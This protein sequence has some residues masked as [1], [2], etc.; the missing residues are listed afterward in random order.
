MGSLLIKNGTVVT[1]G[2]LGIVDPGAVFIKDTQIENVGS[3]GRMVRKYSNEADRTIDA[4]GKIVMPGLIDSHFH[5]CQQGLRGAFG[6]IRQ[7]GLTRYPGWKWFLIPWEAR[8]SAEDVYLS[9]LQAY[10]NMVRVGTTFVSEHGGR[11]PV[12]LA[13]ALETVGIR[14]LVAIST[15]DMDTGAPELP[16]NMLFTTE[17]AI[18]KNLEVVSHW[19]FRGDGLA[20]GVFS[21]RQIIVCTPKLIETIVG[22]AEERDTMVQTHANEGYYE[23]YHALEKH[24]CRP[25]EYL[26]SIGGL[27]SRIIAAH[28][29]YMS[30]KEVELFAGC[31]VGVAH[32]PRGNW[33][34]GRPKL[35][36]MQRLGIKMGIGSDGAT[37]GTIDLFEKMRISLVAQASHYG[38]PYIDRGAASAQHVLEMATI[39][40]AHVVGL[41]NEIGSL[42][43]GKRA[44]LIILDTTSLDAQPSSDPIFT[45]VNCLSGRDVE[46]V[47]VNGQVVMEN[48]TILTVD[49]EG[50]KEEVA[51]R[52]PALQK[53][54][55]EERKKHIKG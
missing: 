31:G 2:K 52:M 14:G 21:L 36:L 17:E 51:I 8:L 16:G 39:G 9:A 5:T 33:S 1:M 35:P 29:V 12:Q 18:K 25:V 49:E 38:A 13:R 24:S 7:L 26:A 54:F 34:M 50:L 47:V 11:H 43:A 37:G 41:E 4:A 28:S 55:I 53:A 3:N 44:D 46:T 15:M 32:C 10:A 30:D 45:I 20:K 23:I 6:K 48:G 40:G 27:S 22:L 19:P 42:E